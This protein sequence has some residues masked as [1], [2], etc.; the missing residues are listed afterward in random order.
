M[1]RFDHDE[2]FTSFLASSVPTLLYE[3][4]KSQF[5]VFIRRMNFIHHSAGCLILRGFQPDGSAKKICVP[6]ARR[7]KFVALPHFPVTLDPRTVFPFA[8]GG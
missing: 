6:L 3:G 1:F 5:I 7:R 4:L 8:Q 2:A